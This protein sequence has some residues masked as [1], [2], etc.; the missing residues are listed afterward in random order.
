MPLN[1]KT[2]AFDIAFDVALLCIPLFV[3]C[4]FVGGLNNLLDM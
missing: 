3:L 4:A 2:S 1:F